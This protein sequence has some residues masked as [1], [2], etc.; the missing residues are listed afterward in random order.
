MICVLENH[1]AI[2]SIDGRVQMLG[3]MFVFFCALCA[4]VGF[5]FPFSPAGIIPFSVF[6]IL[7]FVF[8]FLGVFQLS[9]T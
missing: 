7:P 1:I 2:G 4:A 5:C 8:I 9:F 6:S 3:C